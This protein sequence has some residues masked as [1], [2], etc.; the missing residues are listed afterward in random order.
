[1]TI[2]GYAAPLQ[3]QITA[4]SPQGTPG[5]TPDGATPSNRRAYA[6]LLYC[7]TYCTC[8]SSYG[9]PYGTH[10]C[11]PQYSQLLHEYL[12]NSKLTVL[13]PLAFFEVFT[14]ISGFTA[15]KMVVLLLGVTS[16]YGKMGI[17]FGSK[18]YVAVCVYASSIKS[19]NR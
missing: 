17:G 16:L 14:G 11:A 10:T 3:P 15:R 18:H 6:L 19:I 1:M 9:F 2:T 5:T 12:I 8:L 4:G 7:S 13:Q